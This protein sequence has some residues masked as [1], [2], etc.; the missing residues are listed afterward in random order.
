[1][2]LAKLLIIS[3]LLTVVVAPAHATDSDTLPAVELKIKPTYVLDNSGESQ[4]SLNKIY[5]LLREVLNE[6]VQTGLEGGFSYTELC[7][8]FPALKNYKKF[9]G[10]KFIVLGPGRALYVSYTQ[11]TGFTP[12]ISLVSSDI[13]CRLTYEYATQKGK[14]VGWALPIQ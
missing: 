9:Q 13:K 6:A 1:M 4:S 10:A 8:S 12:T 2:H 14:S 7:D 11:N 5:S 3:L